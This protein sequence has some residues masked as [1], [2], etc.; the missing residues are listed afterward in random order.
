MDKA[1]FDRIVDFLQPL[2]QDP[3]DRRALVESALYG[4]PVLNQINW[5]GAAQPFTSQ[6]VRTLD[7]YGDLVKGQPAAAALLQGLILGVDKQAER[8]A[9]IADLKAARSTTSATPLPL[10]LPSEKL[11][12]DLYVFISYASPDRAIAEQV[13]VYLKAAGLRVFRDSSDIRKGANWDLTIEQALNECQRMVLLLSSSSMPDRKE[14]FREWFYFDQERKPIY[15]LFLEKCKLH[16]RMYAYNYID[17]QGTKLQAALEVLLKELER[18]FTPPHAPDSTDRILVSDSAEVRTLPQALEDLLKVAR[19]PKASIILTPEQIRE[20]A[21]H[22][23]A[24]P[25]EY[26]LGRIA[27]WSEPRYQ[28]DNRFVNLTLLLDQGEDAQGVRWQNAEARRFHDLREVLADRVNDPALVLLGS[29]GS[30]KSTLLR[31]LQLDDAIDRLRDGGGR[32]T[33]FIQLNSFPREG[34][35]PREWLGAEWKRRYPDLEPLAKLLEDGRMLLLL[36]AL[37]EMPH[38]TPADYHE[39]VGAWRGFIQEIVRAGNRAVFSCRSLDYSASLSSKELRV[40]QV[41]VQPM[42]DEQVQAFLKAYLPEQADL[43]WGELQGRPQMEVFRT[44]YFLKLLIEQVEATETIPQGKASLFTG[45]VRGALKREILGGNPL[46]LPDTLLTERDHHKLSAGRWRDPFE[47]P[48]R[49]ALFPALAGLA[50]GMQQKGLESDGAQI[51]VDVDDACA[52]LNHER[53][54]QMLKAGV[55]LNVLDEDVARY[56]VLFFHQLLQ[57]YFAARQLAATPDPTLVQSEW[58]AEQVKPS[59]EET[60]A[61]LADSDPLPPLPQTGWEETTLLAAAMSEQPDAFIRALLPAN[62]PLAAR[63]AS[64]PEVKASETLKVEIRAALI[65]RTQ[66]RQADLRARIAAGLALGNLGDPRFERRSGPYGDYRLPPLVSIPAGEYSIGDDDSSFNDEKPAHTV[67]LEAFQIGMFPVTNAE[68]ALFLAAGGYDDERWWETDEAQAW[69]RGEG[70]NEGQKKSWR[71]TREYWKGQAES[72][73]LGWSNYISEQKQTVLTLRNWTDEQFEEWLDETYPSG[74][75]YRQPA[76]WDDSAFNAPAQ[77]VVGV[78]WFEA[79]AYCAWLSANAFTPNPPSTSLGSG[80][81]SYR[82]PTEVEYE[83]AA[84]GRDGRQYAYG[85][86]FAVSRSNTF[87]SHLRRTTPVGIFDNA[88]PE[89]AFDLSGN[90]YTW[91]S[92]IYDS[93]GLPYPYRADDGREDVN[94]TDVRRVLRGGSSI[95]NLGL[96]RAAFRFANLPLDRSLGIGFRVVCRPPSPGL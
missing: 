58:Q 51:R 91:T 33:F 60:L 10:T 54:E 3:D 9:L 2:L 89:G 88:T 6:L 78:T 57:E 85:L 15:P 66:D 24:Q 18:D 62:L 28:L 42:N 39:R 34:A 5:R 17:A 87:E 20:I 83:A 19:D 40:P 27:E 79:R 63:A 16:S 26:R 8:D 46:F 65:A 25:T 21:Q 69:R 49:G 64:A 96:A 35:V 95:D 23:P 36:D 74:K 94:R 93:E 31:R 61:G 48:D 47:L 81:P 68:Y 13:E 29:P 11:P 67:R 22:K 75:I 43:I 72:T 86:T 32:L 70:S 44:P 90:V 53:D 30:G 77:P 52:L 12:G 55:A 73:I 7:A 38:K 84:R 56:E 37:N 80:E 1:L 45:Y 71:E 41:V 82:L 76:F 14:V 50:F 59:L 92:S 4:N